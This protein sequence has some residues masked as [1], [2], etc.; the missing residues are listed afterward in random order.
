MH[1]FQ[2][3]SK[4]LTAFK[5]C[6]SQNLT[7][8]IFWNKVQIWNRW[9]TNVPVH[10][11]TVPDILISYNSYIVRG[12]HVLLGSALSFWVGVLH[13]ARW[14]STKILGIVE[15]CYI[16]FHLWLR[17]ACLLTLICLCQWCL[18]YKR[19]WRT[20]SMETP[21]YTSRQL[22]SKKTEARWEGSAWFNLVLWPS[23]V[24][25][26]CPDLHC[27]PPLQLGS[28]SPAQPSLSLGCPPGLGTWN[29]WQFSLAR[30]YALSSCVRWLVDY[31]SLTCWTLVTGTIV[32][33]T[34]MCLKHSL[35][36]LLFIH[37]SKLIMLEKIMHIQI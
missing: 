27:P 6:Q 36:S 35:D 32:S 5:M 28:M 16:C 14:T 4:H 12:F 31:S 17:V 33:F 10:S 26:L 22:R 30:S 1:F 13:L 18:I 37:L 20:A 3:N 21:R 11:R 34:H 8:Q 29:L 23:A 9:C 7:I 2:Q 15:Q 25:V 24:L 19:S